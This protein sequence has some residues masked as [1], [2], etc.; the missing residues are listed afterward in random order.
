MRKSCSLQ[1]RSRYHKVLTISVEDPLPLSS[2]AGYRRPI[3]GR[4]LRSRKR[5]RG[6]ADRFSRSV[7][8]RGREV[9]WSGLRSHRGYL[10][11]IG[12]RPFIAPRMFHVKRSVFPW[13]ICDRLYRTDIV[14]TMSGGQKAVGYICERAVRQQSNC[15]TYFQSLSC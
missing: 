3:D 8:K 13:R 10:G 6:T 1:K 15:V 2:P 14:E 4:V 12:C 5:E 7:R 9:F 11:P